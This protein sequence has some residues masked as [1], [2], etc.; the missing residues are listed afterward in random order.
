MTCL[1]ALGFA[2]G[3]PLFLTSRTLQAWMTVEGIDL[4]TIGLI[5]MV[6]VPYSLKFLWSPLVDRFSFPWLGRRRG[7]IVVTQISLTAAIAAM[8]LQ[9]PSTA[10]AFLAAN[11]LLI[12]FLSATQ[13]IVIDAYKVDVLKPHELGAG[14]GVWVLGYRVAMVISG[15]VALV[16]ADALSWPAAYLLMAGLMLLMVFASIFAPEPRVETGPP[17]TLREAVQ[18]PFMEIFE[19]LGVSR[20]MTVL[21]FVILFRVGDSMIVNMTTPFL[22]RSGFA[23]TDLGVIRGGVG[24]VAT[25]LGVLVGGVILSRIGMYRS[26]WLFG[27]LQ[28][29]SNLA[30][31]ALAIAG[32]NYPMM[33]STI[34]VEEFCTGLGTAGLLAFLMSLCNPRFS[35]TQYALL[36][37]VMAVT[38]DVIVAPAGALVEWI[39]WPGFFLIS[40]AAALPPLLLLPLLRLSSRKELY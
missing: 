31:W 19:R 24:V 11:A 16:L 40:F 29:V 38:R 30:Y 26:L 33:V 13:D 18:R 10:L 35:A 37:S 12:A 5:S 25:I 3:L 20:A 21:V 8:A 14:V 7:W 22:L 17:E 4:T 28:A 39:G 36:T 23:Q 15:G 6:G 27:I 9:R 34:V 32:R 2:S 1:I